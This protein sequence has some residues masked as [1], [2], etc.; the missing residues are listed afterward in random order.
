MHLT[1]DFQLERSCTYLI[2]VEVA[3]IDFFLLDKE[4]HH[5]ALICPRAA[6]KFVDYLTIK[7]RNSGAQL[8]LRRL[9]L[10]TPVQKL[11][12]SESMS[13]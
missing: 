3:Q 12:T 9:P 10:P 13:Q 7:V 4:V 6:L 1:S 8:H 11:L 5:V 2:V